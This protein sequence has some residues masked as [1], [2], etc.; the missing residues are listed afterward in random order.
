MSQHHHR[1]ED[2]N[3]DAAHET[4]GA[5]YADQLT[6][7]FTAHLNALSGQAL[8]ELRPTNGLTTDPRYTER[9]RAIRRLARKLAEA[10]RI[11]A[12]AVPPRRSRASRDDHVRRCAA[13]LKRQPRALFAL[14]GTETCGPIDPIEAQ[15]DR[16]FLQL[17]ESLI[18]D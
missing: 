4:F 5:D 11:S 8:D 10:A 15:R 7:I 18:R 17:A 14:M 13:F 16:A 2:E 9:P 6:T 1:P 12:E 3:Q